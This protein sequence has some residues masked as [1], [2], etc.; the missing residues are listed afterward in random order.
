MEPLSAAAWP[1]QGCLPG[2][3]WEEGARPVP[4]FDDSLHAMRKV[5]CPL[6]NTYRVLEAMPST[7]DPQPHVSLTTDCLVRWGLFSLCRDVETGENGSP[8]VT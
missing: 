8:Q 5:A 3:G 1:H 2:G 7:S 6:M 4:T